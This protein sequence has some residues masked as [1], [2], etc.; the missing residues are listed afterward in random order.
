LLLAKNAQRRIDIA[1][2]RR[3][4]AKLLLDALNGVQAVQLACAGSAGGKSG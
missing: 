1:G 3:G 4:R 2:N